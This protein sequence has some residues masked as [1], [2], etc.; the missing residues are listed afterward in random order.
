MD[1]GGQFDI[2][3]PVDV[4]GHTGARGCRKEAEHS[5]TRQNTRILIVTLTRHTAGA[6]KRQNTRILTLL[7]P[8]EKCSDGS[9]YPK[10]GLKL[11]SD[12][13]HIVLITR[14]CRRWATFTVGRVWVRVRDRV[15]GVGDQQIV[16]HQYELAQRHLPISFSQTTSHFPREP[17]DHT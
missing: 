16:N 2:T 17:H 12:L 5:Y 14:S 3:G 1:I 15:G 13:G 10:L 8:G 9:G 6:G 7:R 11:G 4:G